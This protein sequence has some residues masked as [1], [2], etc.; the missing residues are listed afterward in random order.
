MDEIMFRMDDSLLSAAD[1][2]YKGSWSELDAVEAGGVT[3][4]CMSPAVTPVVVLNPPPVKFASKV[5]QPST[6]FC[7]PKS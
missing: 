5:P 4:N 7:H 1:D 2:F 6:E 3:S